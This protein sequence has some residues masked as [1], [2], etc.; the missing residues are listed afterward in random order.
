M[1]IDKIGK[2]AGVQGPEGPA[3]ADATKNVEKS[4]ASVHAEKSAQAEGTAAVSGASPLDRLK[5]GELDVN[6][7]VD[8]R[9]DEATRGLSGL[10]EKQL[11]AIRAVLREQI[12]T[13]PGLSELVRSATGRVPSAPEE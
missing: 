4:F 11:G 5:A 6:G 7:Y 9:I 1:G 3:E 13:D 12:V 8:A 2:N 10:G